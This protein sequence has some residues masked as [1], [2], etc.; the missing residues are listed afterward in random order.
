MQKYNF[1]SNYG[2]YIAD[3]FSIRTEAQNNTRTSVLQPRFNK[4]KR[5][6]HFHKTA[7][8]ANETAFYK[9][10][11]SLTHDYQSTWVYDKPIY[12]WI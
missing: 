8:G 2:N 4:I 5:L 7:F 6:F 12:S 3:W 1:F 11:N 10:I 9:N